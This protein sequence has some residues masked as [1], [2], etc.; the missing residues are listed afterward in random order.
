V[1]V[2]GDQTFLEEDGH[3]EAAWKAPPSSSMPQ[4]GARQQ[5]GG[6]QTAFQ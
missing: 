3:D 4:K 5:Y 1:I 2:S 6:I